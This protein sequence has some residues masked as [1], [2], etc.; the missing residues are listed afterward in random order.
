MIIMI[1]WRFQVINIQNL[2]EENLD[3][4]KKRKPSKR[5]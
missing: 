3:L 1:I 5:N 4:V 2:T